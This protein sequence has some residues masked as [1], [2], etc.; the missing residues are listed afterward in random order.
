MPLKLHL[1]AL[2][3]TKRIVVAV[4][5]A[6]FRSEISFRYLQELIQNQ[7]LHITDRL[8]A[9]L[10][11]Q[12]RVFFGNKKSPR[13]LASSSKK[14][15]IMLFSSWECYFHIAHGVQCPD[16]LAIRSLPRLAEA[17]SF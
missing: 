10:S 14:C 2:S 9:N 3:D 5:C 11:T 17:E 15:H 1:H 4:R 8:I 7:L 13:F 6:N 16:L 12:H